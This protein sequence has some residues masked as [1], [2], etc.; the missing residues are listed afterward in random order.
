MS[1][2]L[3]V[4]VVVR[5]SRSTILDASPTVLSPWVDPK[6]ARSASGSS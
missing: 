4:V 2:A 3:V 5:G 6:A 1:D